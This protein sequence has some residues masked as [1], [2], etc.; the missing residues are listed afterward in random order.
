MG[1][2][3]EPVA[4]DA[5][6]D[7]CCGRK[8]TA[9][10]P[11]PVDAVY[12]ISLQDQPHRTR[13]VSQQFHQIGLCRHVTFYRP[14]RGAHSERA[15]WESH[16]AVAR[17]AIVRRCRS[18]LILEDDVKFRSDWATLAPRIA[19]ATAALPETWWGLFLGHVPVQAYFVR[20]GLLR[21]RSTCLHAYVANSPLLAWLANTV[22]LGAEVPFWR[23]DGE[24]IDSATAN[25]PGMYALFPMA[26]LQQ[27]LGDYRF[28]SR[29]NARGRRRAWN[30]P[31]RWRYYV[32]FRGA[33]W[34]EALAVLL[35][36][37]HR[38]TLELFCR[39][40]ESELNRNAVLIRASA[41]WD[42]GFYRASHP[43]VATAGH[44]PL[45]HYLHYGAVEGRRP[46]LLFDPAYYAAQ[47]SGLGKEA[48]LVH[49]IRV[50]ASLNLNPHP[51]FD[52]GHYLS[53]YADRIPPGMNPLAHFI[54]DGGDAG[55]DPHPLF[56]S[57]W[58][59]SR[60]P[61]VRQERQN[62]LV[63]YLT[64]GWR[65]GFAPHPQFDGELYLAQNPDVAEAGIN[66]LEHFVKHGQFEGRPQPVPQ[67][68]A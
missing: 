28:D 4:R 59:L 3:F 68:T 50:G 58:Y 49:Y 19:R 57:V 67:I 37:Y 6:C 27:F 22:P 51:L 40:A 7:Y 52:T 46:L 29:I 56:D 25:L 66:P 65:Q 35:S 54:A 30:D 61:E 62:P 12:C 15:I 31:D 34:A 48:P 47:C 26:A 10:L 64:K 16:R 1:A 11:S 8:P 63:H 38:L 60:H 32:I 14:V 42:D 21:A 55:L 36:P 2:Y 45:R 53:R 5:S 17:H 13:Q 44:D 24:A 43:D 39:R 41:L 20:G 18:A 23:V 9:P 33:L